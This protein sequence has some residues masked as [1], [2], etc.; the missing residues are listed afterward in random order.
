M[1]IIPRPS[2]AKGAPMATRLPS[3][4]KT[5]WNPNMSFNSPEAIGA[6]RNC[7]SS[8]FSP[9]TS[10]ASPGGLRWK[11]CTWCTSTLSLVR[12]V[13]ATTFPLR[14]TATADPKRW[15]L[16]EPCQSAFSIVVGGGDPSVGS[17]VVE[18]LVEELVVEMVLEMAVDVGVA[19]VAVVATVV[20]SVVVSL[21]VTMS[22]VSLF[23]V[24]LISALLLLGEKSRTFKTKTMVIPTTNSS[25]RM[26]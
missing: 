16:K 14:D 22:S 21:S 20:A 13:A 12:L 25:S 1:K 11:I 26:L 8:W 24:T 5:T 3:P 7:Q 23:A 9:W 19:G 2:R 17:V 4:S 6:P 15:L 18:V 10:K